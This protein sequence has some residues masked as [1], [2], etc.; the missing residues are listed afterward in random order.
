MTFDEAIL[1][2]LRQTLESIRESLLVGGA[3]DY[4]EYRFMTGEIRGLS[5]AIGVVTDLAANIRDNDD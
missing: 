2:E 3:R 4:A 5:R 1:K